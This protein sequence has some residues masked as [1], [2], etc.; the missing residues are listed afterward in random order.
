MALSNIRLFTKKIFDEYAREFGERKALKLIESIHNSV[1]L[2]DTLRLWDKQ[3]H[4]PTYQEIQKVVG[5]INWFVFS[6]RETTAVGMLVMLVKWEEQINQPKQLVSPLVSM[7]TALEILD[8]L[9]VYSEAAHSYMQEIIDSTLV[10]SNKL[11][12]IENLHKHSKVSNIT[13]IAYNIPR[14]NIFQTKTIEPSS[15]IF[16]IQ[17]G[18]DIKGEIF[19]ELPT[20]I[21]RDF[22]NN[23]YAYDYNGIA[24]EFKGEYLELFVTDTIEK[25]DHKIK[26]EVS[27]PDTA[28]SIDK[29]RKKIALKIKPA[30]FECTIDKHGI[31]FTHK[32]GWLFMIGGNT[33]EWIFS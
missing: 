16:S 26:L 32:N 9:R 2:N 20:Q 6:K 28:Y 24:H 27:T 18:D 3:N 21:L 19:S 11:T 12:L 5:A 22:S 30:S 13:K 23:G 10:A 15:L 31:S 4:V 29:S 8:W 25:T 14:D 7:Q 33:E 1:F 17:E